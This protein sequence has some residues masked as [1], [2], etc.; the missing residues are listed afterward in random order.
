MVEPI[1]LEEPVGDKPHFDVLLKSMVSN[2]MVHPAGYLAVIGRRANVGCVRKKLQDHLG[3][4]E[5][6][7]SEF[8]V[9]GKSIDDNKTLEENSIVLPGPAARRRGERIE[10][11]FELS[12]MVLKQEQDAAELALAM[13]RRQEEKDLKNR[14]KEELVT[15]QKQEHDLFWKC[16]G[17]EEHL[18]TWVQKNL[19]VS[20]SLATAMNASDQACQAP[21]NFLEPCTDEQMQALER[22]LRETG[23]TGA[24][25]VV[26]LRNDNAEI[27]ERFERSKSSLSSACISRRSSATS[28][29]LARDPSIEAAIG[30]CEPSVNEFLLFHG[31]PKLE[32]VSNICGSGFD[33]HYVGTTTDAGWYGAGFYFADVATLS[34]GYGRNAIHVNQK[35]SA[36][37]VLLV[38]RV[39]I[40]N[41]KTV[42]H[43]VDDDERMRFTA[44]CL[45]PGGVFGPGAQF[46]SVLG[47]NATEYVCMS[48]RQ[49][50]PEFVVLYTVPE[51]TA[52]HA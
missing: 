39:I 36:C 25:V 32:A 22:L 10:L 12:E 7:L 18:R 48:S 23:L 43:V 15:K 14:Q 47:G 8:V 30:E 37:F 27:R 9:E 3:V 50:Y 17:A 49:I 28:K 16:G 19:G 44:E 33:I 13:Q 1:S 35:Y 20:R 26:A 21:R 40:G 34:H 5:A 38:N 4:S 41:V 46:H 6:A 42:N 24:H 45:G 52:R 11:M 2:S 31:T 29:A 51:G